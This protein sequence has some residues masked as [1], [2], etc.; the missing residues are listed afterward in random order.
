MQDYHHSMASPSVHNPFAI[1]G[2]PQRYELNRDTIER[3][4]RQRLALA[5][6]DAGGAPQH[7]LDPAGLNRA[8][9]VLLSDE[10]RANA[11][12]DLLG[13]PGAGDCKDLPD[14]FLMDMMM[15][16]QE[17]EEAIESGGAA[18]REHWEQWSLNERRSYRERVSA[19]FESLPDQPD[20]PALVEI[21]IQLNAW[22]YIERLIEQLDP[23]YDAS[24]ADVR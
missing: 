17:I 10:L 21:R 22:R 24:E 19:L 18:D 9:S 8:R 1:L 6:P 16:R 4:Y 12:L 2:L 5:H 7:N 11:L 20:R 13:G 14:G 15:Q 3:A 23:E